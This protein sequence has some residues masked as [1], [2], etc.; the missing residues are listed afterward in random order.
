MSFAIDIKD[1]I[2]VI[3]VCTHRTKPYTTEEAP[4]NHK[5]VN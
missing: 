4:R 2:R 3:R 1:R 5:S